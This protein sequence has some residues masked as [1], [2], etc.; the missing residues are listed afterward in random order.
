M[1][2][3]GRKEGQVS[4]P[5]SPHLISYNNRQEA[6]SGVGIDARREVYYFFVVG[7]ES[8]GGRALG[9][10]GGGRAPGRAGGGLAPARVGGG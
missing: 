8:G 9:R 2:N 4:S 1:Y 3:K 10:E 6:L 7:S 5:H